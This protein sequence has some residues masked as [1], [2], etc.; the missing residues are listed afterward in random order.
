MRGCLPSQNCRCPSIVD[1]GVPVVPEEWISATMSSRAC[2]YG[3]SAGSAAARG[4][5]PA[6]RRR[7]DEPGPVLAALAVGRDEAGRVVGDDADDADVVEVADHDAGAH[8]V[9]DHR[10]DGAERGER[11]EVEQRLEALGHHDADRLAGAHAVGPVPLGVPVAQRGEV[12]Q[13]VAAQDDLAAVV[14]GW[15]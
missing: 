4:R 11:Q 10:R 15:L 9:V 6:P 1:F 13:A 5:R 2:R 8:G 12:D 14:G 3:Y 7:A